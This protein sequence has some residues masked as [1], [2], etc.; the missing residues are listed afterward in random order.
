[1]IKRVV[2]LAC[3]AVTLAVPGVAFA[4]EQV[5]VDGNDSRS[6]LDILTTSVDHNERLMSFLNVMQREPNNELLRRGYVAWGIE[7][8]GDDRRA[9]F[10]AIAYRYQGQ[11]RCDVYRAR[12]REFEGRAEF[13]RRGEEIGCTVNRGMVNARGDFG[14]FSVA[15]VYNRADW[16]GF[17]RHR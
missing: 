9:E 5:K 3:A 17:Y 1:M 7:S 8:S 4:H 12:T 11:N 6:Q 2:A 13:F 15:E 16:T 10:F 14:W